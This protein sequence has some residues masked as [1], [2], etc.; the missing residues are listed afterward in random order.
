MF[1]PKF[2][3]IYILKN[4]YFIYFFISELENKI[5]TTIIKKKLVV[6]IKKTK[7]IKFYVD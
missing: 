3:I 1:Y 4:I 6:T 7:M 2:I 5:T